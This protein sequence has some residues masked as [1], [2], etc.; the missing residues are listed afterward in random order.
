MLR[1]DQEH[2]H[3]HA[4]RE[5]L[6]DAAFGAERFAKT[7]E[8]LREGRLPAEGLALIARQ[9]DRL[10]GTLRFWHVDAGGVPALMLGPVAVDGSL[11]DQ[12]I[13]G[14]LIRRGLTIAGVR[15]HG[16]VI[17]V[18]DEPYYRRFGFERRHTQA[19]DLP[20]WYDPRRFLGLELRP[21]ALVPASG[22]VTASGL[23]DHGLLGLLAPEGEQVAETEDDRA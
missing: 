16:A 12:G 3:D 5:A 23:C 9:G 21:G 13:G 11:R 7:S 15:G 10:V 17:L 14:R 18:G 20:G 1:I 6:L 8:R 4:A 2:V 22:M 19:L